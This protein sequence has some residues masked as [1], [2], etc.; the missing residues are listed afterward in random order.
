MT[1]AH[2]DYSPD[3]IHDLQL[4]RVRRHLCESDLL[5]HS[6]YFFKLTE[7]ASFLVNPHHRI[8]CDALMRVYSGETR[9]LIINI[10]PGSSKTLLAVIMFMSWSIA[11]NPWCRFLHLSYARDLVS[12]NSSACQDIISSAEYQ[13]MW[14]RAIAPDAKAKQRW[15]VME[16]ERKAGGCYA[17]TLAG[18][19]TGFRAGY[20][21]AGFNGAILIDDPL[22]PDDAFHKTKLEAAGRRLGGTVKSRKAWA[23][24]PII[25]IMQRI[26]VDDATGLALSGEMGGETFEVVTIPAI[27]DA[28][29]DHETSYWEVKEPIVEL[30]AQREKNPE[31]FSGQYQQ[32]PVVEGGTVFKD[33]WW[34]Y[35]RK[36]PKLKLI[37]VYADTAMKTGERN[38][39]SVFEAW[40]LGADGIYLLDLVRDKWEAPDL[41]TQA[42][43]FWTKWM[44]RPL[45]K[46]QPGATSF[47]VEDK[48]SGTGLIQG[49][50]R[51]RAGGRRI[52]VLGIPREIDK[53]VR[54]NSCTP[55]I[56][57]GEVFLPDTS[58]IEQ[59]DGTVSRGVHAPWLVEF[60]SECRAFRKDMGHAHDD[61]IDPMMDAIH[62]MLLG[63]LNFY[64]GL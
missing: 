57:F 62:D 2:I 39:F 48:A 42:I 6:R 37:G 54:A 7:G 53:V 44:G 20:M 41:E 36:L 45:G 22:K 15:N 63:T 28:G 47:K 58:E 43:A 5:W 21:R 13:A 40:G 50:K 19:V 56:R 12:A 32:E 31:I 24:T 14:P 8:V 11:K 18:T 9:N 60:Q 3:Q 29:T 49:L 38:D 17:T 64:G 25:M 23:Q 51:A 33:E 16:G 61:Q 1:A 34:Q 30:Q 52:P 27:Q 35:Y 55:S 46:N 59:E 4:L 26:H 10:P